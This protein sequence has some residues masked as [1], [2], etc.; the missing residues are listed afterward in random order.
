MTRREAAKNA[1]DASLAARISRGELMTEKQAKER[2]RITHVWMA[3]KKR[4]LNHDDPGYQNYGGRG[5]QVCA[6]W[7][8]SSSVFAADM[9][10][11]PSGGMLERNNNEGDYEPSNCRWATR[12]EQNSNRRNCIYVLIGTERCTLAEAC[13][14]NCLS[15][16]AVLKRIIYRG[17]S[18]GR[19]L[20]T[21]IGKGN[22][23]Q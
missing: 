10:P 9:G 23:H 14:R 18:V 13:R 11:R 20:E 19:A 22:L 5:I 12:K 3:M 8:R 6:R 1:S 16:K 4:C 17:W 21:P 7:M 15:Y 2:R